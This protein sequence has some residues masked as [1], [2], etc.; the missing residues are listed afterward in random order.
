MGP[1][2]K[3]RRFDSVTKLPAKRNGEGPVVIAVQQGRAVPVPKLQLALDVPAHPDF[4][5]LVQAGHV[6]GAHPDGERGCLDQPLVP[7]FDRL[8]VDVAIN[9]D[10]DAGKIIESESISPVPKARK[11][12]HSE[13][14]SHTMSMR[15]SRISHGPNQPSTER[16]LVKAQSKAKTGMNWVGPSICSRMESPQPNARSSL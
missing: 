9:V 8:V 5:R 7:L 12:S 2:S 1:I 3:S 13:N 15:G 11:R 10:I 16:S 14:A 6:S 4:K